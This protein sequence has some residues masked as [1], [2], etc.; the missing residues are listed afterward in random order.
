MGRDKTLLEFRGIPLADHMLSLVSTVAF[1]VR[2][3][4]KDELP[5][6][7]SGCGPLGGIQT[8]L[9]VSES[10]LN[11]IVAVDLPLLEPAFLKWFCDRMARSAGPVVACRIGNAFPLCLGVHRSAGPA[12][13]GRIAAGNLAIQ[14]FIRESD[15]HIISEEEVRA[16]GFPSSIF[17]NVNT[18]DDWKSLA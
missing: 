15:S 10:D 1:P 8:A 2:I 18:P 9:D 4:G 6:K 17:H 5:D 14:R 12:V 16:A 11:L 3:V 13:T 7:I